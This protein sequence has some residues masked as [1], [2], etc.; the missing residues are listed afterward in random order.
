MKIAL[1]QSHIIWENPSENRT[2]FGQKINQIT[3][4]VDLI[5]LP[6]MFTSGFTMNPIKVAETMQGQTILWL[7]NLSK[8]KNAAITGSLVILEN[9]KFY[10]R[11]IFIFPSGEIEFYNKKHLFN[12]AGENENYESG[13][14]KVII[15]YLDFKICLQ[16]CYDL[17]FP[18]FARNVE[19]YDLILYVANWS[20]SR[21]LA[22]DVL[23]KAR[24]IENMCFV[25][26]VNRIGIDG[27][28]LNYPGHSQAN[29][30]LG[31]SLLQ[32]QKNEGI[33]ITELN[34]KQLLE[35]RLNLTFLN[36]K[37]PFLL[38]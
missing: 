10:N 32:P 16:V 15:N 11:M 24:A 7:K 30:F 35:T 20:E 22:W 14:Q 19:N 4:D 36:D 13:N 25:V 21:I 33:F 2:L 23:L 18:V 8:T 37:D 38:L 31:N 29:D 26:G 28:N 6:E 12:L 17:R 1:I 3:E 9:K 27:S 34:K 5:V